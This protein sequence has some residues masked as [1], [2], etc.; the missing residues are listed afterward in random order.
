MNYKWSMGQIVIENFLIL[1]KEQGE[2]HKHC[3]GAVGDLMKL[4]LFSPGTTT[5]VVPVDWL[6][7][8]YSALHSHLL[9][10]AELIVNELCPRL[11]RLLSSALERPLAARKD[12][13][14]E[15]EVLKTVLLK[16]VESLHSLH[17]SCI[18][19]FD[20]FILT[21]Q[22]SNLFSPAKTGKSSTPEPKR[23]PCSQVTRDSLIPQLVA[24][25]WEGRQ[26]TAREESKF[27]HAIRGETAKQ[28]WA[29]SLNLHRNKSRFAIPNM[30]FGCIG[31]L[32][33][34]VLDS[35]Q[36]ER[37]Y[38]HLN[39]CIILSQT[40]YTSKVGRREY[41]HSLVYQHSIWRSGEIWVCIFRNSVS[42]EMNNF[43]VN[44]GKSNPP[45]ENDLPEV[46]SNV[47]GAQ[48]SS[49][50]FIMES[51]NLP[52]NFIEALTVKFN[53]KNRLDDYLADIEIVNLW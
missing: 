12:S 52:G 9:G 24:K 17:Q 22:D 19:G 49:Y 8:A 44:C 1:L 36:E 2:I 26:V 35:M 20:S 23:S 31:K 18:E 4:A 33:N 53:E 30:T 32:F 41:L 21:L 14:P 10:S 28:T 6:R 29:E 7:S 43:L 11:E 13:E 47:F 15:H 48:L 51:F 5:P 27:Q 50:L 45:L 37:E 38:A 39:Q 40:F 3:A 46:F 34:I 25:C 16:F 42:E